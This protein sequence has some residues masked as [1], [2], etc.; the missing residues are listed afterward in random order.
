MLVFHVLECS[1][2][3]TDF[4]FKMIAD[5]SIFLEFFLDLLVFALNSITLGL[6]LFLFVDAI[7][8]FSFKLLIDFLV[9]L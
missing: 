2:V 5:H 3:V 4:F 9:G 7:D 6:N 1:L 8:P